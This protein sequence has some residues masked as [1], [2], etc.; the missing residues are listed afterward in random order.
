MT[1]TR[2]MLRMF[3]LIPACTP[4]YARSQPLM[5]GSLLLLAVIL[6]LLAL[7]LL[8]ALHS[9][10]KRS[11]KLER[12]RQSFNQLLIDTTGVIA[13]LDRN[14][15][16]RNCSTSL[17]QLLKGEH[18]L[19]T[20]LSLFADAEGKQPL[21]S[22][23]RQQLR[24][25]G[26]WQGRAWLVH[27]QPPQALQLSIQ[28]V[29]PDKRGPALYLLYAQNVS[30]HYQQTQQ[31]LIDS[32]TQLPTSSLFTEQLRLVL[33]SCNEHFP[34]AAIIYIKL[35][36]PRAALYDHPQLN[37]TVLL[38]E[39]VLRLQQ[40]L[41][42]SLLLARYAP[43]DLILLIPPHLCGESSNIYLNQLAHKIIASTNLQTPEQQVLSPILHLG[44][45]ISPNDGIT[46]EELIKSAEKAAARSAL[47]EHSGL[48]FADSASQQQSPDYLALEQALFQSVEQGN[49]ELYYQPK[50]QISQNTIIGFEAFLRWP[51]PDKGI[52]PP[53][54]F[55]PLIEA[56]GLTISLDRV[57]FKIACQQ[58]QNWQQAGIMRGRM[59]LNISSQQFEHADFLIFMQKT[60]NDYQLTAD[61]FELE[62]SEDVF[63]RP[64]VQLK[65]RLLWLNK[66]GYKL[67]LDNFGEGIASITQLRQYPI[68]GVKLSPGLAKA[69]ENQE[70]QRNICAT[71][72]RLAHYLELDVAVSNIES[73]AQ[74]YLLHVLGCNSQ[75]GNHF[76]KAL[77]AEEAFILLQH[78]EEKQ[79]AV[80]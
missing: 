48:T 19:K 33:N 37:A 8:L 18:A 12:L 55:M 1:K 35:T 64:T 67:T 45:S 23:I 53:A 57:A 26:N 80:S 49:F 62:L 60:L 77:P 66:A 75:Q 63:S 40:V 73:E 76:G 24:T 47:S 42:S 30:G 29:Q 39:T 43:A 3:I 15:T 20:T 78:E 34:S 79:A 2:N 7:V 11:Y 17:K 52:L 36:P 65:E 28:A 54:S 51:T 14:L 56:S 41:P 70:Q 46:A 32:A 69:V 44:I 72:I 58:V 74:A 22:D 31:Q 13:V 38:T 68:A 9:L 10:S 25:S 71:L 21:D 61:L 4:A 50:Y 6:C 16:I 5:E 27:E 59:A